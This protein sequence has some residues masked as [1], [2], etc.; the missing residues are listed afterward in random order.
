MGY[1]VKKD[2]LTNICVDRDE[3]SILNGCK[4]QERSIP[5]VGIDVDSLQNIM[6]FR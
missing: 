1:L 6:P 2:Q 4:L 5:G 3:D